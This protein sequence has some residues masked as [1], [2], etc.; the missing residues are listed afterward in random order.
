MKKYLMVIGV[1]FASAALSAAEDAKWKVKG[2]FGASY[3]AT[4]VSDNWSGTEKNSQNWGLKLDASAEKDEVKTN[5]I[6]TLKEEYG[7]AKIAGSEEQTSADQVDFTS[8]Y[9]RKLSFYVNPY[10]G[11]DVLTQ[12]WLWGDPVTYTESLG[13]GVWI[14]NKPEQQLKT[15]AGIACKQLRDTAKPKVLAGGTIVQYSSADDPNTPWIEETKNTT[16]GEWITNY[17]VLMNKDVKFTSEAKLFTSFAGGANLR[18]DNSLYVKLTTLATMQLNYLWVYNYDNSPHPVWP[19]DVEKR[20]TL[21]FGFSY[22]L[23]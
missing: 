1:I 11:L 14:V 19:Q 12:H 20:L 21:A 9:S 22:N 6:N 18:W 4:S 13:D 3:N 2:M 5:W 15:R 10:A 17:E 7:K 8:V 23:F 16:G